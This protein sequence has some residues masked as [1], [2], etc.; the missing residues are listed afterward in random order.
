VVQPSEPVEQAATSGDFTATLSS[1]NRAVKLLTPAEEIVLASAS[2]AVIKSA[3][4][5]MIKANLRLVVRIARDYETSACRCWTSS[6]KQHRPD[7][8]RRAI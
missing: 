8:R 1:R 7:E 2:S 3:R 4:E 6:T 5:H